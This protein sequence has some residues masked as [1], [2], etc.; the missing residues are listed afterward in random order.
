[1]PT[2]KGKLSVVKM[3]SWERKSDGIAGSQDL[4][5]VWHKFYMNISLYDIFSLKEHHIRKCLAEIWKQHQ[6]V[7][8]KKLGI[9]NWDVQKV[10]EN[11]VQTVIKNFQHDFAKD[12]PVVSFEKKWGEEWKINLKHVVVCERAQVKDQGQLRA[13]CSCVII[14]SKLRYFF[15]HTVFSNLMVHLISTK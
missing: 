7:A 6:Y 2:G 10:F 15:K 3:R 13:V 12:F 8:L 5:I 9:I 1:M 14:A 4:I 11:I